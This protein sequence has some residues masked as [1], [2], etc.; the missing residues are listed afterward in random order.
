[1]SKLP[2]SVD[3]PTRPGY[4][5]A[6]VASLAVLAGLS[7]TFDPYLSELLPVGLWQRLN[8]D[9]FPYKITPLALVSAIALTAVAWG[10][11]RTGS[12]SAA[13]ILLLLA[14]SQTNGFRLA[15]LDSLDVALIIVFLIWLATRL[16]GAGKPVTSSFVVWVPLALIILNL[17]NVLHQPSGKFLLGNISL[18][19]CLLLTLVVLNL[20]VS[21]KALNFAIRALVAVAVASAV[22][23]IVQFIASYFFG[24]HYT[25]IDPPDSAF[26]PTPIGMVMRSSALCITAQHY[27]SF[28]TLAVPFALFA[29]TDSRRRSR[30]PVAAGLLIIFLGIL[31]SWNF[32]AILVTAAIV[33]LFPFLRWPRWPIQIGVAYA[34][35]SGVAYF[36]GLIEVGYELTFGDSGVAKG[37]SQRGTL[38]KLGFEKLYRDPWIGEG[39]FGMANFSGNFWG[40]PVHNAYVQAMTEVG[41]IGAWILI[42]LLLVLTTQLLLAGARVTGQWGR[43]LRGFLLA[44]L[45]LMILMMSEPMLDH[46]NTW[47]L[48]GLAEAALLIAL[49]RYSPLSM[50]DS[51]S[52]EAGGSRRPSRQ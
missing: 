1:L 12:A 39:M 23:G 40:R 10:L 13:G 37:V 7:V 47:L 41:M 45:G 38:M 2:F 31:V 6:L 52:T 48:L 30:L 36:T 28:L 4:A 5:P 51:K 24:L 8:L 50:P 20:V 22:I 21:D 17:P 44:M 32:G 15:V 43:H 9:T 33:G 26:K 25:L 29:L 27:S 14:A 34:L 3:G 46:S 35:A 19:R 18:I 42:A 11:G 16:G 49:G